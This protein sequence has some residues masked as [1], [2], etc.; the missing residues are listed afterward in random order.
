MPTACWVTDIIIATETIL[1]SMKK[2][3]FYIR[4]CFIHR[5]CEEPSPLFILLS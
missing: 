5:T 3:R 4:V 1:S 2:P